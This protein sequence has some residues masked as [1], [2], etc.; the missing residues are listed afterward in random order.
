M[1]R[2]MLS[3]Y[4]GS[5]K[6]T[7]VLSISFLLSEKPTAAGKQPHKWGGAYWQP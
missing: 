6:H 3:A 2:S 7:V 5:D 1:N 4:Q